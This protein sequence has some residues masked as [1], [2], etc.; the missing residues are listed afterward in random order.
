[1]TNVS[2]IPK[3][4][5][6]KIEKPVRVEKENIR[7][8]LKH[9]DGMQFGLSTRTK[10]ENHSVQ[11]TWSNL[12]KRFPDWAKENKQSLYL[13]DEH[14]ASL[15]HFGKRCASCTIYQTSWTSP[16]FMLFQSS[17]KLTRIEKLFL[18]STTNMSVSRYTGDKVSTLTHLSH[19][20]ASI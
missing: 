18:V 13:E 19:P 12:N 9:F 20:L 16:L 8:K 11:F 15:F 5:W 10:T 2:T 1:M 6:S 17:F 14:F 3:I 4:I 7:S